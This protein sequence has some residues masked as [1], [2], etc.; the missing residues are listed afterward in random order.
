MNIE[1]KEPYLQPVLVNT[2]CCGT[3]P[4]RSRVVIVIQTTTGLAGLAGLAGL[5]GLG[6]TSRSKGEPVFVRTGPP[7]FS[8]C[9]GSA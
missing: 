1:K 5:V 8:T 3:S 7:A 9:V 2:N 4:R 6:G